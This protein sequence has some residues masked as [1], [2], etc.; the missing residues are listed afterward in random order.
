MGR[1]CT[2]LPRRWT[3]ERAPG[4]LPVSTYAWTWRWRRAMPADESPT[5]SGDASICCTWSAVHAMA[6][7][8]SR[9]ENPRGSQTA[10]TS[11]LRLLLRLLSP[12]SRAKTV[13]TRAVIPASRRRRVAHRAALLLVCLVSRSG[14]TVRGMVRF[15]A[16]PRVFWCDACLLSV[17]VSALSDLLPGAWSFGCNESPGCEPCTALTTCLGAPGAQGLRGASA[18]SAP[19][20]RSDVGSLVDLSR[21]AKMGRRCR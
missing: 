18:G 3:I 7:T 5:S 6:L 1:T 2:T 4:N 9:A 21:G 16:D 8:S 14:V 13:A 11:H 20:R 19:S 10:G 15:T 17:T 12:Q